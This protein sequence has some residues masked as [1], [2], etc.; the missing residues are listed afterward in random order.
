MGSPWP[1]LPAF[2]IGPGESLRVVERNRG[3]EDTGNTLLLHRELWLDFDGG[4]FVFA[5]SIS[6][7]MRH[8]WRLDMAAP[9]SLMHARERGN[10]LLVTR[11][12]ALDGV[13]VRNANLDL[14]ALGRIETRAEIPV[15][16][17]Q[18]DLNAVSATL[19]VPP[20]HRLLVAVGVDDAPSSWFGR[21][22]RWRSASTNR[23]RRCGRG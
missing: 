19:N 21:L 12:D 9:Y 14:E 1:G 4:G 11:R 13:E 5:D 22:S 23:S 2:R 6:G 10:N 3:L 17:W 15:A 16:G 20:G 8:G 7:T 18:T